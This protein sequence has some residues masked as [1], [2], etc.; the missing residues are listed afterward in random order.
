MDAT[1]LFRN[2]KNFE[3]HFER[4][5]DETLANVKALR[6][7]PES[8]RH[9]DDLSYLAEVCAC[10]HCRCDHS[11]GDPARDGAQACLVHGCWCEDWEDE[12]YERASRWVEGQRGD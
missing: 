4:C 9:R 11:R 3:Q 2:N 6:M 8:L 7:L 5:R 1:S 12:I 10:G